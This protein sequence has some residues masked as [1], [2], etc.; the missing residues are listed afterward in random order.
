MVIFKAVN[1]E[2]KSKD[3]I[4]INS[5]ISNVV[6]SLNKALGTSTC[7]DH[8]ELDLEIGVSLAGSMD[9]YHL[10]MSR[11]CCHNFNEEFKIKIGKV[12]NLK[13]TYDIVGG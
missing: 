11:R 1:V 2:A 6:L 10:R 5:L 7:V 9:T 3:A 8:P 12:L 4:F 13:F